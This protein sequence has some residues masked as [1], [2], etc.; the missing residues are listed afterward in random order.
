VSSIHAGRRLEPD[1]H[2]VRLAA[3]RDR[4]HVGGL[5]VGGDETEN[6][7]D[8][9]SGEEVSGSPAAGHVIDKTGGD[10]FRAQ[11][12]KAIFKLLPVPF[13]SLPKARKL[14]PIAVESN[15]ENADAGASP[16]PAGW[17]GRRFHRFQD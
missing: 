2:H 14:G 17:R 5:H 16:A 8:V 13:Q 11:V 6:H 7:I 3:L 1:E 4:D 9:L 10:N 12:S 15:V